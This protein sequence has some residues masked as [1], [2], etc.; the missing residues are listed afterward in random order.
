MH[1]N[2]DFV[3]RGARRHRLARTSS[4]RP[5]TPSATSTASCRSTTTLETGDQRRIIEFQSRREF[6]AF[7]AFPNDLG[8]ALPAALQKLLAANPHIEGIWTWTQDG[9]PWRAGPDDA[10]AQ[11]RVLAA[12]TNSNTAARRTPRPRPRH[13]SRPRSRPTGLAGGSRTTPAT[14]RPIAKAMASS[15]EADRRRACTSGRSP[16]SGSSRSGSSRRP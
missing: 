9:G 8:R 2:S 12:R 5:S 7:G 10:R 14:V 1:T 13:R 3:P 16:T 4:C 15:R 6:E 11:D